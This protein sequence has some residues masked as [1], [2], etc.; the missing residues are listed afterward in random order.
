LSGECA[1]QPAPAP[2][3][4]VPGDHYQCYRVVR[5]EALRPEP[6]G[7]I[8]QF[9]RA[10]LVLA[11]PVMLCNP[12]VKIHR[13]KRY[14]P[15]ARDVHLVCYEPAKKDEGRLRKVRI[16]NQFQIADVA[17]AER[18]MFCVPSRKKLLG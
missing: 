1:A 15:K 13:G 4:V 8:D 16:G 17:V 12:S 2:N 14:D 7:V 5:A 6:I 18:L 11:R 9:G 10:E 3:V